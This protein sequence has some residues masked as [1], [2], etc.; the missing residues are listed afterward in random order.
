VLGVDPVTRP[1]WG[2]YST[3]KVQ[4]HEPFVL[5]S[6]LAGLTTRL[7]FRTNVMVVP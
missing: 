1:G 3:N 2:G 4:F 6:Y 5:L 7:T